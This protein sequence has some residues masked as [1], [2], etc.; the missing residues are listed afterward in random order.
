MTPADA[1]PPATT[2]PLESIPASAL[3]PTEAAA[4][5]WHTLPADQVLARLHSQHGGLSNAAAA[6]RLAKFG[7]NALPAAPGRTRLAMFAA[8]FSDFMI[9]VLAAAAMIA[10][11]LGEPLQAG[12][13]VAIVLL[14][15]T[16]GFVQETRAQK[17]LAA[18]KELAAPTAQA[19]RDR[20]RATV[21]AAQLVPGDVVVLEAGTRIAA[22]MRLI[23]AARLAVDES[24][25]TG[26]SAPVEKEAQAVLAADTA[27]AERKNLAFQGTLVAAGRALGV[28][29]ATGQATEL[30]RIARLMSETEEPRTPLQQRLAHFGRRLA[31]GVLVICAVIFAFG[32][33]R[34]EPMLLMFLTAVS[35]AVAAIPEALPAVVSIALS[36]GAARMAR[37]NALARRLPAVE[38]LGSVT[39]ICADKTGT[40]TENRLRVEA[41]DR[42]E[43]AGAQPV[44][45]DEAYR[46]MVLVN[47]AAAAAGGG[48][49]GDPT[50]IALLQAALDADVDIDQVRRA[51]PRVAELP[52]DS[53]R[54]RMATLHSQAAGG[55]IVYVKGAPEEVLPRC[56]GIDA[57]HWLARAEAQA[58]RGLRV[59]A[60]ARRSLPAVP[61]TL[62]EA[63]RELQLLALVGLIDPPR[64]HAREAVHE[65][66]GAGVQP[67][68]ITGDHP[69]T[70]RAIAADLGLLDDGKAERIV[71][72]ADVAHWNE[73]KLAL[74]MGEVRVVARASAEQKIRIVRALQEAGEVVAMTGDGVNDGP[75][76]KQADIGVAMGRGGTDV[77]REAAALVL[78]DDNFAT[79][80][81]AV[82]EGRRIYDNIRKFVRFVMAGNAGEIWTVFL[83]PFLGL[84]LPLSPL[85]ILWV[86]FVTDGL[87][88]LAL[89]AQPAERNVMQ[90]PPRPKSESIFAHGLWQHVLW[91]GVLIGVVS[92][93]ACV[94]ATIYGAPV[95]TM[96]FTV[97]TFAQLTHVM[98]IRVEAAPA[99][100]VG[101]NSNRWLL[102]SVLISVAL[103]LAIVYVPWLNRVFDTAPLNAEQLALC[104]ALSLVVYVGVEIEKWAVRRGWLYQN[105]NAGPR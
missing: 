29:V 50:E 47:D 95:Q 99:H 78:L 74:H 25:L 63:E 28:V 70:A 100:S 48:W 5:D 55:V 105:Q 101:F 16:L 103:H 31:L 57:T 85:Q 12:A 40:L 39:V 66:L 62:E 10:A 69:A 52:F 6:E 72:G 54:K 3:A 20:T 9:L 97:L 93:G 96:T 23:E 36:V 79:I 19:L 102:W 30:G 81:G 42:N 34:G 64:E 22:D 84:P 73:H 60:L 17:A 15:A 87:P 51:A 45:R 86:N 37:E 75:A 98:A 89:T 90:R 83:A 32:I 35:L 43:T 53:A 18:L 71:T 7:P 11:A 38:A 49:Q 68:M 61:A 24:A 76:L 94:W 59:L 13:I 88:G 65:C 2:L 67:V 46:A 4:N 44:E 8:Q 33:A 1:T 58:K 77:A 80:V 104:V 26:E 14:N 82:R 21:P 91:V 92:L 56:S 41:V 27:L